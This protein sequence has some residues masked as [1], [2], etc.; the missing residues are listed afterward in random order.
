MRAAHSS[1]LRF[2]TSSGSRRRYYLSL[3]KRLAIGLTDPLLVNRVLLWFVYAFWIVGVQV[4]V[5]LSVFIV[6]RYGEYPSMIDT[7]MALFTA[8]SAIALWL[9]FF[10]PRAYER[11][12]VGSRLA[13]NQ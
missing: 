9:A 1:P 10:P 12:I 3:K 2:A 6:D 13:R 5:A 7:G 8:F 4:L 11:W